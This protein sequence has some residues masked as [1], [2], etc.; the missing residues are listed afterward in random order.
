M[1]SACNLIVFVEM[2]PRMHSHYYHDVASYTISTLTSVLIA[3][4]TLQL[5][6]RLWQTRPCRAGRY[7]LTYGGKRICPTRSELFHGPIQVRM[8]RVVHGNDI[9]TAV[10][11]GFD[12]EVSA[13]AACFVL[14]AALSVESLVTGYTFFSSLMQS[15][16]SFRYERSNTLSTSSM[17]GCASVSGAAGP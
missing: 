4:R 17:S 14:C 15:P 7:A 12:N 2:A 11:F 3:Y 13:A 10:P 1:F 9:V 8:W 5:P 6:T 16:L